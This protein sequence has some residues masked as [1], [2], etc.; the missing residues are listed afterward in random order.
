MH[1]PIAEQDITLQ[2]PCAIHELRVRRHGDGELV[3][4]HGCEDC[5]VGEAG[6]VADEGCGVHDVVG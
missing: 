3:P 6:G 4:L 2:Y 1:D 5:A